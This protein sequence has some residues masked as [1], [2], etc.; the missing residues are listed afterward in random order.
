MENIKM[1]RE[2]GHSGIMVTPIGLGCWQF[3]KPGNLAGK[4]WPTL[5]D[6][7]I[8]KIVSVS[9]EGGINWFDTAELYGKGTSERALSKALQ[10]S[11]KRPG[12]VVIAT[13][14]WPAFR[15]ASNITSTINE[16][17]AALSPYPIDLY[18]IHQ[19]WG[20]SAEKSEMTAM[21]GLIE[22]KLIKSIGVSNFNARQMRN[23]WEILQRKG[24]P[25]A[26]NQVL[27]N[28]LD[29]RIESDGVMK[30]AK[31]LGIS[32]IAYSPLAQ[33]VV[34][35]KYHDNPQLLKNTGYRK[36]TARF[37]RAGLSKSLPVVKL[38]KELALKYNVTP[39]QVAL[40]WMIN[41]NG[42]TVVAIPGATKEIHARENTGALSFRLSPDDL[43]RLDRE[44]S[45]FK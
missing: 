34:T 25:L 29:R 36:Y 30:T 14:W 5:P 7:L 41:Y 10:S 24:I 28:L 6:D 35:G 13:K 33:G 15:F 9:L 11:G 26:S 17:T 39:S 44:S 18:Q 45:I 2:L 31:E 42:S 8:D 38:V 27:Y 21:A 19:P 3:S 1:L 22:R 16:R 37:S 12:E 20:F 43:E 40:S 4:F 32:L 23:A